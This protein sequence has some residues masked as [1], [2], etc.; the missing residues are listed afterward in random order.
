MKRLLL[1]SLVAWMVLGVASLAALAEVQVANA[2][3]RAESGIV[4][5]V[6]DGDT[7]TLTNGKRIRLLQIDTP[8]LGRASATRVL[9]AQSFCDSCRLAPGRA[10]SRLATRPS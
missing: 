10:R 4:A 5:S 9:R 7:L 2:E 8:E 3:T 1:I 6:Y